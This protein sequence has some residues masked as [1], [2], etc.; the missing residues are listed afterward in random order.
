MFMWVCVYIPEIAF[1]KTGPIVK[2]GNGITKTSNCFL[3]L[4][5]LQVKT[6]QCG[7]P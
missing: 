1:I 3:L 4:N 6:S 2:Q 5:V 7:Q